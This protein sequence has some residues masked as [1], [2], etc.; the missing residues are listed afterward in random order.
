MM[1]HDSDGYLMQLPCELRAG[2]Q[3]RLSMYVLRAK[4][5]LAIPAT[6]WCASD[7]AGSEPGV[8]REFLARFPALSL[9]V[10]HSQ[11]GSVISLP[12]RAF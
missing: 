4:V 12:R 11:K 9:G 8:I 7:V 3:K 1:W 5:R 6:C 2:I 10:I